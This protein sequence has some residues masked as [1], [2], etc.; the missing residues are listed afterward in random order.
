MALDARQVENQF[1][2]DT[3]KDNG[4]SL[5]G[6]ATYKAFAKAFNDFETV[7]GNEGDEGKRILAE[8]HATHTLYFKTIEQQ[9]EEKNMQWFTTC[10]FTILGDTFPGLEKKLVT[11]LKIKWQVSTSINGAYI[12]IYNINTL[13]CIAYTHT[14]T[15]SHTHILPHQ[16]RFTPLAM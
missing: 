10:V 8:V 2:V 5:K 14:Y 11:D 7:G 9:L 16:P 3:R 1:N 15:Y 13:A 6:T 4:Y 12:H